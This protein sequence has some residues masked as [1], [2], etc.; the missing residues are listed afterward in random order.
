MSQHPRPRLTPDAWIAAGLKALAAEGPAAIRAEK[1]ARD[2]GATKGSFYWH[3]KDV[4]DF[5]TKMLTAWMRRALAEIAAAADAEGTVTQKLYAFAD[6]TSDS[7]GIEQAMRAWAQSD[8]EAN[9]ALRQIDASRE[10]Y[11]AA[12]L[13]ELDLT[14]P[15]FARIAYGAQVGLA[16]LGEEDVASTM[17]TLMA[18]LLALQ[19]A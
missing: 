4:P 18:A 2:L 5:R 19:D 7:N 10:A 3:F 15:D 9:A 1:L 17:S 14:N 16:S 6:L 13:S 11:L 12:L 8:E